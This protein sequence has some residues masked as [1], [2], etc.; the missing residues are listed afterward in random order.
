MAAVAGRYLEPVA[1]AHANPF[2]LPRWDPA[3]PDPSAARELPHVRDQI[4]DYYGPDIH[5]TRHAGT[6]DTEQAIELRHS[7]NVFGP[8][9][10]ETE[11]HWPQF[12]EENTDMGV[13]RLV[14]WPMRHKFGLPIAGRNPPR[15]L[16]PQ[17]RPNKAK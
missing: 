8:P 13:S 11:Q 17:M 3:D 4:D 9:T 1:P 5:A 12:P 7:L 15:P 16:H 10:W 6:A 2:L 14:L